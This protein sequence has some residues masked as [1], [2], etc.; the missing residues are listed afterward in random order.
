MAIKCDKK[1]NPVC[2]FPKNFSRYGKTDNHWVGHSVM[3]PVD[4]WS[5]QRRKYIK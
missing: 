1:K 3:Q 4:A 5:F 2:T